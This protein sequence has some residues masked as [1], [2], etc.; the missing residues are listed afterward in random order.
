[1]DE[2]DLC[3]ACKKSEEGQMNIDEA[4]KPPTRERIIQMLRG[5]AYGT[6]QAIDREIIGFAAKYLIESLSVTEQR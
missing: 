2:R 1:M 4:N 6:Y 5:Y 3:E